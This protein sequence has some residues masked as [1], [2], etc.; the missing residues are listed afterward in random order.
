[1][2]QKPLNGQKTGRD[3]KG[4]FAKGNPGGGRKT[5]P[6]DVKQMLKAA[7]TD[8]ARL[9]VDTMNDPEIKIET[10][11][12]CAK[13]VMERVYGKASQPIEGG[14]ENT[15]TVLLGEAAGYAD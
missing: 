7:T 11:L 5:I 4:R 12:D 15:I 6:E 3:S 13:T 8:A 2:P 14:L 10:R 9:L 1:M